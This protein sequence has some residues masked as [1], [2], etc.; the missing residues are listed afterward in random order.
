VRAYEIEA[1]D[2]REQARLIKE[3]LLKADSGEAIVMEL[4]R[5]QAQLAHLVKVLGSLESR[6]QTLE[7]ALSAREIL[8]AETHLDYR[9]PHS[10]TIEA[11]HLLNPED[12]FYNLEH[13]G[14]GRPYR[15]TGP[16][17]AFR[18]TLYIDRSVPRRATAAF[19]SALDPAVFGAVQCYVDQKPVK[20]FY[21][22][23]GET[24]RIGVDI[25]VRPADAGVRTTITFML[26][27]VRSPR[28]LDPS[29]NDARLLGLAFASLNVAPIEG[30]EAAPAGEAPPLRSIGGGA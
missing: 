5:L 20:A 13:D 9:L 21:H 26:P 12:G 7:L 10:L 17:K 15:W 2:L 11:D 8:V 28:D 16:G 25:P 22:F 3:R 19:F 27:E 24:H 18:F 4:A 1:R 6:Q 29:N 30:S 23:E 14:R